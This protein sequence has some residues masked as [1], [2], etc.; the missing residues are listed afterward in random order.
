MTQR[1]PADGAWEWLQLTTG[2]AI[3]EQLEREAICQESGV[4]RRVGADLAQRQVGAAGYSQ[5]GK[6][7]T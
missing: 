3:Y 1:P 2:W 4:P 5:A 7:W 6:P